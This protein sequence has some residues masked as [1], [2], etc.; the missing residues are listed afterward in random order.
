MKLYWGTGTCAIGIHVLLEEIGK[1]YETEKVDVHGGATHAPPFLS[2]NPKGKVPALLRDDGSVLTEFGAIATWLART[3]PEA[4]LVPDDPEIEAR[5]NET[6]AYVEGTIHGQGYARIFAPRLFAPQDLLHGKLGLRRDH[7]DDQEDERDVDQRG[8]VDPG[9]G[10]SRSAHASA[11][12]VSAPPRRWWPRPRHSVAE[13]RRAP[14]PPARSPPS[15][16]C[17]PG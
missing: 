9:D 17:A 4:G 12:H 11:G 3:N 1:P 10:S 13:V 2:I 5:A 16:R 8:D 14:A 6:T 7:E 15:A